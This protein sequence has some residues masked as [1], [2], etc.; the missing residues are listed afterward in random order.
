MDNN[1]EDR[2]FKCE[3][4]NALNDEGKDMGDN[5]DDGIEDNSSEDSGDDGNSATVAKVAT[6][7]FRISENNKVSSD[8]SHCAVRRTLLTQRGNSYVCH[9]RLG[10]TQTRRMRSRVFVLTELK[11]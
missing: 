2:I 1:N 4:E 10:V 8:S 5:D 11:R 6:V 3:I 7:A 9:T